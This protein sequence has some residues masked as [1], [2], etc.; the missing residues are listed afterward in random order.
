VRL[1]LFLAQPGP[2]RALGIFDVFVAFRKSSTGFLR[3][4]WISE[5]PF[6]SLVTSDM[7]GRATIHFLTDR[8]VAADV[9]VEGRQPLSSG[10]GREHEVVLE[11]L[12]PGTEYR[13]RVRIGEI[14]SSWYRLRSAPSRGSGPVRLAFCGDSR[15]GSAGGMTQF[16]GVNHDVFQRIAGIAHTKGA[17]ALL[18]GGDLVN[19]YTTNVTDFE[20]QLHAWKQAV[21]GFWHER[22]V[23]IGMGNHE[24]LFHT[25][26]LSRTRKVQ[27]D[28]WPYDTES[29][30]AVVGRAVHNPSNGPKPSD[31]RRPTYKENVFSFQY[32][33]VRVI[34]FNNNYWYSDRPQTFGGAPEGYIL[35][36]QM[37]W[38]EQELRAADQDSTVKYILLFAQEPVFPCGGHSQDSMWY[39]GDNN[40]RAY[41]YRGGKLHPES[42]GILDVRN[43]FVR[44]VAGSPKV[45]AVLCGDEHAYY[46]VRID[47]RVPVG[48]PQRDDKNGNGKIEWQA[49][50]PASALPELKR[51]IWFVTCGGGGAPYYSEGRTPW[52]DYWQ[53][54]A[55]PKAGFFYTSQHNVLI[56]NADERQI[57]MS[58]YNA[59]GELVDRIP[60]LRAADHRP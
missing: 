41:T 5:G 34:A 2:D 51:P 19:G 20:T 45:A 55:D 38:I 48:D 12:A 49:S 25:F 36:D 31:P 14:D 39:R 44:A 17:H 47:G 11:G 33:L 15:E 1:K 10:E 59:F 4:P 40:V 46:R 27:I 22:P 9:I 57:G 29:A 53:Q 42:D 26:K 56:I 18:M 60:N 8:P 54:Q 50:E 32:G 35:D 37:D 13:Y 58:C 52:T 43:R 30:E 6:V 24:T 3:C 23:F 21:S 28:R 7:P 16:M